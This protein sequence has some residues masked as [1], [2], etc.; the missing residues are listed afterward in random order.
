LEHYRKNS[1]HSEV[2]V[3][4]GFGFVFAQSQAAA[5]MLLHSG[6]AKTP[7]FPAA[8]RPQF[9]LKRSATKSDSNSRSC[10][11]WEF[12]PNVNEACGRSEQSRARLPRHSERRRV[13]KRFLDI[14]AGSLTV[15]A[16]LRR[17]N[18]FVEMPIR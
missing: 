5:G 16:L 13:S 2:A 6:L 10:V 14:P 11:I 7:K 12:Y 9:F 18:V 15:A 17:F 1:G 8:K 4:L 3:L